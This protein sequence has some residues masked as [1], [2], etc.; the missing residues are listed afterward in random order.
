MLEFQTD[1][2]EPCQA[3]SPIK[4]NNL[5]SQNPEGGLKQTWRGEGG[6]E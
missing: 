5:N 1:R 3:L 2:V 6:Q 4:L